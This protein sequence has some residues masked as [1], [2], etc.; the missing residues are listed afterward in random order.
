MVPYVPLMFTECSYKF[1]DI[2]SMHFIAAIFLTPYTW[3]KNCNVIFY[4]CY[5]SLLAPHAIVHFTPVYRNKVV[6]GDQRSLGES[7]MVWPFCTR[8]TWETSLLDWLPKCTS[9]ALRRQS[10]GLPY[11]GKARIRPT[12]TVG[13]NSIYSRMHR[14]PPPICPIKGRV[15]PSLVSQ[16]LALEL[17][18]SQNLVMTD[19]LDYTLRCPLLDKLLTVH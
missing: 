16:S 8:C 4:C 15:L 7:V 9:N 18:T 14:R 2:P 17:S 5:A 3:W 13:Y 1:Q 19:T 10:W 6:D 11:E 12:H